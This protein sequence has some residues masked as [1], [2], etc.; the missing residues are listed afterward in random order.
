MKK[1]LTPSPRSMPSM[2][3]IDRS[4]RETPMRVLDKPS[5]MGPAASELSSGV[6]RL[7]RWMWQ[8]G[9]S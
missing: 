5:G 6:D 3:Q 2:A 1:L 8:R 9:E 4:S 7:V